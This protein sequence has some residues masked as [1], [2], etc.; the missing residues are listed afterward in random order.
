MEGRRRR[1]ESEGDVHRDH[2]A[3]SPGTNRPVPGIE[4]LHDQNA[5]VLPQAPVE[6]PVATSTAITVRA[7]RWTRQSMNPR[8]RRRRPA[9]AILDVTEAIEGVVQL[10]PLARRT[11]HPPRPE[12]RRP[13]GQLARLFDRGSVLPGAAARRGRWR[14][15]RCATAPGPRSASSISAR[16]RSRGEPYRR[17][18]ARS[19]EPSQLDCDRPHTRIAHTFVPAFRDESLRAIPMTS[20][21]PRGAGRAAADRG[22]VRARLDYLAG[23]L[24]IAL[25]VLL[26]GSRPPSMATTLMEMS[27]VPS[28]GLRLHL[29]G[30]TMAGCGAGPESGRLRQRRHF[31]RVPAPLTSR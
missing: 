26:I 25:G 28:A 4:P 21:P 24:S 3:E 1:P 27:L 13:P 5:R 8:S 30:A 20:C 16:R 12:A 19:G 9:Q 15:L 17:R 6:L 22:A 14:R 2:S 18:C 11:P 10:I 31:G 29:A 23:D 7:P